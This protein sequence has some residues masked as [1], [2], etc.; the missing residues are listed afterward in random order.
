MHSPQGVAHFVYFGWAAGSFRSAPIEF[1]GASRR[2]LLT[3]P[4]TSCAI[5]MPAPLRSD[6]VRDHS[7]TQFGII[8][9]LTFGFA[10]IPTQHGRHRDHPE[11]MP[12][13]SSGTFT[14]LIPRAHS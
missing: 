14:L 9:E 2:F 5:G 3:T 12:P 8:P 6:G 10:G 4:N 11:Q 7:G 13:A 1:C